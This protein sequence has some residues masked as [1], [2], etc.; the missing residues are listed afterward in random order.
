LHFLAL[1]TINEIAAPDHGF[2]NRPAGLTNQ[3]VRLSAD[4]QVLGYGQSGKDWPETLACDAAERAKLN[5]PASASFAQCTA[6]VP[7]LNF[8]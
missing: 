6:H 8:L 4:P 7:F 3:P 2:R 5:L 1:F